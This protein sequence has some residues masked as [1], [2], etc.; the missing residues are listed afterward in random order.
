MIP[1][2]VEVNKKGLAT[3]EAFITE[4]KGKY[5]VGD[6]ITM[7]DCFL[8]PQLF[9]AD[10]YGLSLDDFPNI[11]A[12]RAALNEVPAFIKSHAHNQFD[13]PNDEK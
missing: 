10:R 11:K 2:A 13:T 3:F 8:I 1:W 12:V 7:A 9:N 5:C 6:Q 4:T